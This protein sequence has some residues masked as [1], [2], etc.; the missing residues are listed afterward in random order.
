MQQIR[1]EPKQGY[2]PSSVLGQLWPAP[3][4]E[5]STSERIRQL[6]HRG[7][8]QAKRLPKKTAASTFVSCQLQME[9]KSAKCETKQDQRDWAPMSSITH[10]ASKLPSSS[11]TKGILIST[12]SSLTVMGDYSICTTFI[13]P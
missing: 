9:N 5:G 4:K 6:G 11:G 13:F 7:C 10:D 2:M 12:S 1:T 8:W 3:L